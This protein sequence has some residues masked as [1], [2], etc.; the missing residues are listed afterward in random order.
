MVLYIII[1]EILLLRVLARFCY[2]LL[3]FFVVFWV[4]R[5]LLAKETCLGLEVGLHDRK[6]MVFNFFCDI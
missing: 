3:L 1:I 4:E 5:T 6:K 2:N